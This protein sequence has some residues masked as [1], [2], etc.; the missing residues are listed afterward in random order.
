M[1]ID[2][3]QTNSLEVDGQTASGGS[4]PNLFINGQ[5]DI[6]QRGTSVSGPIS[7]TYTCA[8]RWI[9]YDGQDGSA[10]IS[11][12]TFTAGQTDVPGGPTYYAEHD[13][14]QAATSGGPGIHQRIEN[15]RTLNDEPVTLSFY[16]KV[17]SGTLVLTPYVYQMFGTSGSDLV[18]TEYTSQTI[19]VTTSWTLHTVTFDIPSITGKTISGGDDYVQVGFRLPLNET[20]TLSV[21]NMKAE[22]GSVATPFIPRSYAEELA[23]CQRYYWENT[24]ANVGVQ[25]FGNNFTL[26]NN[27]YYSMPIPIMMRTT[28]TITVL[29][30][31]EI[32]AAFNGIDSGDL[33][34]YIRPDGVRFGVPVQAT[35]SS[36]ASI[37]V[38]IAADAE[39]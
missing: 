35:S 2:S 20:W 28:P 13:M 9:F 26:G 10:D 4:N 7:D 23:L 37:G 21:T 19:T 31:V 8:D 33:I 6:W 36:P 18:S 5:F 12:N 25:Q 22:R 39:L 11:R 30:M 24:S 17:A 16:A 3:V 14:T 34:T 1:E 32:G 15:V 27:Y 29:A 38:Q